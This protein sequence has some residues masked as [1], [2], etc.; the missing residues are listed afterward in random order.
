MRLCWQILIIVKCPNA[1]D[2]HLL[3]SVH[4]TSVL[5]YNEM[6][7]NT[8]FVWVTPLSLS[9]ITSVVFM[10]LCV[11]SFFPLSFSILFEAKFR[12]AFLFMLFQEN[13]CFI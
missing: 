3:L 11:F 2:L 8:D 7:F 9:R 13:T 5:L 12:W 6:A 4:D 1:S 10:K